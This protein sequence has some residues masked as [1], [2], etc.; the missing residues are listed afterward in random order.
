MG[1]GGRLTRRARVK[2][3][4]TLAVGRGEE[5]GGSMF[6]WGGGWSRKEV[7]E[8]AGRAVWRSCC[9][10]ESKKVVI[11]GCSV[12]HVGRV[13]KASGSSRFLIVFDVQ[14]GRLSEQ[15]SCKA[16]PQVPATAPPLTPNLC[17][18]APE[19]R[20]ILG[21]TR[22]AMTFICFQRSQSNPSTAEQS[23]A[24]VSMAHTMLNAFSV[25][26]F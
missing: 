3:L 26:E 10:V 22:Q 5:D 4:L 11:R 12:Y 8:G 7:A 6:V 21:F 18:F 9:L 24:L 19:Y 23:P 16:P 1:R 2:G 13:K 25:K 14:G 17:T 20:T 15:T